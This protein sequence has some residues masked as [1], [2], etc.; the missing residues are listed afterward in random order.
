MN[1]GLGNLTTVKNHLQS[2]ALAVATEFDDAIALIARGVSGLFERYTGR[3]FSRV[4]DDQYT[5]DADRLQIW[6]PRVPVEV[7]TTIEQ[8]DDL[9]D[10][11]YALTLADVI[12]NQN[13]EKGWLFFVLM[14]G[15]RGSILR[16]TY[17]GG[18]YFNVDEEVDLGC[19]AGQVEVPADLR[20]AWLMQIEHLWSQRDK[21]G[22]GLASKPGEESK[23][24]SVELLPLVKQILDG[25]R[26]FSP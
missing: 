20:L 6:L 3:K 7:I 8:Q 5:V 10:G 17:T 12:E 11:F 2:P 4:E 16:I 25:Y 18:Y 19:P 23:L 24:P 15:W 21:L 1:L 22:V 13:L 9:A 14:A 26:R